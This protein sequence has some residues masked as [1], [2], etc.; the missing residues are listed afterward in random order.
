MN[1]DDDDERELHP[2]DGVE[3]PIDG[4]LDLHNF[5][6]RDMRTL[7]PDYIEE[8]LKRDITSLRIIH[9]KGTGALQK[10]VHALLARS[11][12]VVRYRLADTFAGGW[13]ATLVDLKRRD[14]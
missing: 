2:D 14:D 6:P 10:G 13:G 3:I 9:G 7:I 11:P 5:R 1:D 4:V 12:H 8:C